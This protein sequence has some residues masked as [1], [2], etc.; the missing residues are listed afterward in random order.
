[1]LSDKGDEP[2]RRWQ[3]LQDVGEKDHVK[4]FRAVEI[5][6]VCANELDISIRKKLFF[7][8]A[9]IIDG[10]RVDF[11]AEGVGYG[12]PGADFDQN[13]PGPATELKDSDCLLRRALE[14]G[15]NRLQP[16]MAVK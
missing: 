12:I 5:L 16:K 2:R 7:V 6:Q 10:A 3:M 1:M 14:V 9:G 8:R 13:R 4:F 15:E 11:D